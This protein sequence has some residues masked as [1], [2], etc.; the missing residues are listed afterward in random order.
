MNCNTNQARIELIMVKKF[1]EERLFARIRAVVSRIPRGKVTTYGTV[2]QFLGLR[3]V[4]LVGFA[5]YG[6]QDSK[7]PCH[8]VIKKDGFLAEKY[9]LGGWA[10]QKWRLKKEGIAFSKE[11]RVDL[12]KHF[13]QPS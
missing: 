10:E 13:W 1:E 5:L 7:I 9:S 12:E 4:R 11:K 6:N 2:A 8:R 3:D